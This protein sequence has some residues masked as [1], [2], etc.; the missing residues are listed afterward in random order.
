[1][2]VL[3]QDLLRSTFQ[4]RQI[5]LLTSLEKTVRD[6]SEDIPKYGDQYTDRLIDSMDD[7]FM[8]L[9]HSIESI[10]NT[11]TSTYFTRVERSIRRVGD[12]VTEEIEE[13]SEED[14]ARRQS[15]ADRYRDYL[16]NGNDKLIDTI[17]SV[18]K[19]VGN[20]L[21]T[22][23]LSLDRYL[24]EADAYNELQNTYVRN[25]NTTMA[26]TISMRDIIL[27][28]VRDLNRITGGVYNE[29]Q[30]YETIV[31][32]VN[33]TS[34]K[35][36]GFYEEYGR[37]FLETQKT[38]NLDLGILAEFSDKFYRKYSF[39]SVT[40]E[41]LTD[42]IR[43]NT[44]GTSVSED[45]LMGFMQTMDTD[46]MSLAMRMGG[47]IEANY[48]QLQ[49]TVT[50]A[51]S[52][53]HSSGYDPEYLFNLVTGALTG[54]QESQVT[55]GKLGINATDGRLLE[56]LLTDP[57]GLM[58]EIITSMG[59]LGIATG[60]GNYGKIMA[61][62]YGIDYDT[63]V[64]AQYRGLT[65]ESYY[66]F[67]NT[68]PT[69]SDP[70]MELYVSA[71]ERT[72]NLTGEMSVMMADMS[73]SLGM[74]LSTIIGL[75]RDGKDI[76]GSF[77]DLFNT[78]SIASTALGTYLGNTFIPA[79]TG[80]KGMAKFFLKGGAIAGS[81]YLL[82]DE[83]YSHYTQKKSEKER[84]EALMSTGSSALGVGDYVYANSDG[85]FSTSDSF[86]YKTNS[87][88]MSNLK[89][90]AIVT[91][92]SNRSIAS[93]ATDW[94]LTNWF[95][96]DQD[97]IDLSRDSSYEG[98]KWYMA[99]VN[100][101]STM[102]EKGD[103][104]LSRL[105]T[106][107]RNKGVMTEPWQWEWFISP[108]YNNGRN[109]IE[110][111]EAF[112]DGKLLYP[113][114]NWLGRISTESISAYRMG[115]NYVNGDQ[116]ALV[117]EGEAIIPAQYNPFGRY[118]RSGSSGYLGSISRNTLEYSKVAET[119]LPYLKDIAETMFQIRE[120]L[121]FWRMDDIN[122]EAVKSVA[123]SA[124]STNLRLSFVTGGASLGT[125]SF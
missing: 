52:W 119:Y 72:A 125:D 26:A 63:A 104:S 87:Q 94:I 41:K 117:H 31:G 33:A 80:A 116:L 29:L 54:D 69:S 36:A 121:K 78:G 28:E 90:S 57:A 67:V 30:S 37:L 83:F 65:P 81:L 68:R 49:D 34:I 77:Y 22:F 4:E 55:L 6:F 10:F 93:K 122:R 84:T 95:G 8:N 47:D 103:D 66:D 14:R 46:I 73:R 106:A 89:E 91:S 3:R 74:N 27:E 17:K 39:S 76:V 96:Y 11:G 42:S 123:N 18:G 75:L 92:N 112:G 58:S 24:T 102:S 20:I 15:E 82:V 50:S 108:E 62:A 7:M 85:T 98:N 1:M 19:S 64:T 107:Y 114:K 12:Q 25:A 56:R 51:Y 111:L 99:L 9:S 109:F 38:M 86:D 60:Y 118:E 5:T 115:T 32:L 105:M 53:L 43:E 100:T 110:A 45:A 2:A 61:S 124:K 23:G 70:A 79:I 113:T 48:A 44:S 97:S 71:E 59:N 88:S 120:F 40:M 13:A 16:N 21:G 35:N 101:A